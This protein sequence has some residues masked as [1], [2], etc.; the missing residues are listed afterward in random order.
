MIFAFLPGSERNSQQTGNILKP[1]PAHGEI[2]KSSETLRRNCEELPESCSSLSRKPR[3]TVG[4]AAVSYS[5]AD[6]KR[7]EA[8]SA[9]RQRRPESGFAGGRFA[10][11]GL[12]E[13]FSPTR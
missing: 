4:A 11:G 5:P 8:R 3:T 12:Q 9:Q 2:L 10:K 6:E 7:G 13:D 1:Y